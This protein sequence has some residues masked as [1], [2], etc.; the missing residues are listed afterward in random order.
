MKVGIICASQNELAPFLPHLDEKQTCK[1]AMLTFHEGTLCGFPAVLA[2][3]GICKVNAAICAQALIDS[4]D[5]SIILN[6]GT[7]G[8]M[9]RRV[10]LFDTVVS[11]QL[12]YHD[13]EKGILTDFHPWMPS[14]F[15]QADEALLACSKAAASAFPP[16]HRI[17]WGRTVT[18]EAFISD[19][20]REEINRAFS[21]LAVDMES[22]AIA[23][24]CYA[25]AV[26]FLSVRTITDTQEQ[27][28]EDVFARNCSKASAISRDFIL[29]LLARLPGRE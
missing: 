14:A 2:Y 26:P 25:N 12:A 15:F 21:P 4:F 5:V 10:R 22:A 16:E 20:G 29:A 28:G 7:A 23:H 6:A 11:S 17:L 8:G 24:V 1:K 3:S 18:G 9:D 13:V 19:Q 27:A